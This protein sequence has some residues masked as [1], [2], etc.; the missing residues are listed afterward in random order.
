MAL[1]PTDA[2]LEEATTELDMLLER[3]T[4]TMVALI[5]KFCGQFTENFENLDN[6]LTEILAG[7]SVLQRQ[8]V[9]EKI[10]AGFDIR[11]PRRLSFGA[12]DKSRHM[13]AIEASQ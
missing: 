13:L 6:K 9:H 2:A 3:E 11:N 8:Y 10:L 4:P 7:V 1:H 12:K 5:L